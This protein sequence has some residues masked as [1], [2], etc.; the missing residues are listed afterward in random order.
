MRLLLDTHVLLWAA[1]G[2]PR[3]TAKGL[4]LLNDP[5]CERIFSVVSI[6]EIVIKSGLRRDDFSIDAAEL[7]TGLLANGYSEL[8]ILGPHVLYAAR[9]PALHKDPFDRLLVAQT[10]AEGLTLMTADATVAAYSESI[11]RI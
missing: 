5:Q 11:I 8:P 7:R 3:L 4:A 6:W 2:S 1:M 9:L 10:M